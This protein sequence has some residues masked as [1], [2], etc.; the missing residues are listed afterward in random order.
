MIDARDIFEPQAIDNAKVAVIEGSAEASPSPLATAPVIGSDDDFGPDPHRF[1]ELQKAFIREFV[2]NGGKAEAAAISAGYGGGAQGMAMR[3]LAKPRV[4][5]EIQ[6]RLRLQCGS[7]LAV[8]V[9]RL[10]KIAETS[11]DDRAAVAA[12]LGLM[13]RFGMAPP[14]GPAV[15]VQVNNFGNSEAQSILSEVVERRT[16]RLKRVGPS[17]LSGIAGTMPDIPPPSEG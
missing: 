1:T 8:A 4:Q 7:A 10:M 16:Q 6:R 9:G 15:N 11:T 5:A 14:K 2:A 12:A 13:D 17:A 3:N